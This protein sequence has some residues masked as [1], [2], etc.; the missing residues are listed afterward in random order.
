MLK[1]FKNIL[2]L[3]NNFKN[4]TGINIADK[5]KQFMKKQ[6]PDNQIFYGLPTTKT[7]PRNKDDLI[8][9]FKY[10]TNYDDML[11]ILESS[12]SHFDAEAM[13]KFLERLW[14]Y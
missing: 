13:A 12:H 4:I 3:K 5:Y 2:F 1:N 7:V 8:N 10:V 6:T 11:D 9:K 14:G